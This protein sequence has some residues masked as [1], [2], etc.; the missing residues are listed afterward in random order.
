RPSSTG[1][2][3]GEGSARLRIGVNPAGVAA[4]GFGP[5]GVGLAPGF[6]VPGIGAPGLLPGIVP[7]TPGATLPGALGSAIQEEFALVIETVPNM[8]ALLIRYQNPADLDQV[9]SWLKELD[10]P[11][12]QVSIETKLVE[13]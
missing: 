8:N 10:I 11:V 3:Q 5:A 2:R 7:A 6:G 12:L 13:V 9:K 4:A 1:N